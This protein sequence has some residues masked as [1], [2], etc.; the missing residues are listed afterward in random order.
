MRITR[1]FAVLISIRQNVKSNDERAGISKI[2]P[3]TSL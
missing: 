2:I 1:V 3:A